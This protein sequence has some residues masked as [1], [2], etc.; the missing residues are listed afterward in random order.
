DFKLSRSENY[1]LVIQLLRVFEEWVS[2]ALDELPK[3]VESSLQ[4]R[5][6]GAGDKDLSTSLDPVIT[7]NWEILLLEHGK[8]C[9]DLLDRISRQA[10]K[11]KSLRDGLYTAQ[12]VR[13]ATRSTRMN[14][15]MLLFTMTTILYLPPTF[16]AV[17]LYYLIYG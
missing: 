8:T 12:Q 6:K 4:Y 5:F 3:L 7:R 16:V 2:Q 13:K 17:G 10:D 15:I 11:V 9:R 14:Q 1:F